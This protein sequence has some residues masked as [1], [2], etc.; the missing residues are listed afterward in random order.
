M[1]LGPP[2]DVPPSD[3][4]PPS[5]D[6][7]P[8]RAAVPLEEPLDD[9]VPLDDPLDDVVPPDDPP[10]DAVP[11]D[12]VPPLLEVDPL[13]LLDALP[14]LDAPPLPPLDELLPL[15][16]LPLLEAP[17]PLLDE[18]PPG[19]SGEELPHAPSRAS[20]TPP[21][22]QSLKKRRVF[23]MSV[24]LLESAS[25]RRTEALGL[26][27]SFPCLRTSCSYMRGRDRLDRFF[28]VSF[29]MAPKWSRVDG[30]L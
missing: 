4:V 10:D 3:E 16:G 25:L 13:L 6:A 21:H 12:D 1:T 7:P 18:P 30:K 8:S 26:R 27:G 2:D 11:P 29:R 9:A 5:D 15:D 19:R 22:P 24:T 23:I 20:A 17:P 28:R 14:L